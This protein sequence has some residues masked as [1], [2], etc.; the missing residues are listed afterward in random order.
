MAL[1]YV[2]YFWLSVDMDFCANNP[3]QN[4]G[5]CSLME[6]SKSKKTTSKE[7]D[8][9]TYDCECP[10]GFIGENCSSECTVFHLTFMINRD[11]SN[12]IK[13][14]THKKLEHLCRHVA[15]VLPPV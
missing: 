15:S 12:Q 7:V 11:L 5:T 10:L 4:G 9:L 13:C 1:Y 14:S 8:T 3:C 6:G 2:L